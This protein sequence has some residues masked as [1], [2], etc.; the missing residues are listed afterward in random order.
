MNGST[1]AMSRRHS[2]VSR[3]IGGVTD[4]VLEASVVGSFSRLGYAARSRLLPEFTDSPARSLS[5][6]TVLITGATSGIGLAA[7]IRL[8]SLGAQ[9][10]FLARSHDRAIQARERIAAASPDRGLIEFDLADITDLDSVRAFAARWAQGHD[11]L[12]V[13]I[14]NAGA[15]YPGYRTAPSGL[16]QTVAGQLVAPFLL[17][18]LLLG[19]PLQRG[20]VITV[21]S[22]GMYTQPLSLAGLNPSPASYRGTTAYARVKRAQ[23]ELSREWA[24]RQPGAGTAFHSMHPGW[25]A[26]PGLTGTLPR[27][28][29]LMGPLLRTPEEGAD[30]IVW[31]ASA[32]PGQLGTG[33]FWLDRRTRPI[34]RFPG[35][36]AADEAEVRRVWEWT[37]TQADCTEA[38]P[39]GPVIDRSA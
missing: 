13:L 33:Q 21:S 5:G 11:R 28:A 38:V 4:A 35:P 19:G 7:A 16:E 1:R 36:D 24:R 23:V 22:G 39:G 2:Q 12:D 32:D 20:R 31:L 30:T 8:A 6:Q 10:S 25:A 26:T 9:V 3:L 29:R 37:A 34:H 18:S 17:T 15:L 14:H 27:F